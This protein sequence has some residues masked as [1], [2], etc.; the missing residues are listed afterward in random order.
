MIRK[1]LYSIRTKIFLI[2]LCFIGF[3]GILIAINNY[4]HSAKS[5]LDKKLT[6]LTAFESSINKAM[7]YQNLVFLK[8][9]YNTEY[10]TREHTFNEVSYLNY[11][12]KARKEL[13]KFKTG[14]IKKSKVL[15]M[16]YNHALEEL[17]KIDYYFKKITYLQ[18]SRGFRDVGMEGRMRKIAH[19]IESNVK[20]DKQKT[21]LLQMR[22]HEKDYFLRGDDMYAEKLRLEAHVFTSKLGSNDKQLKEA[23]NK[24]VITFDSIR[25]A[26]N[27]TGVRSGK[28]YSNV[29]YVYNSQL[30]Y[31]VKELYRDYKR[32]HEEM[33]TKINHL[34]YF[35]TVM[36]IL[37]GL[38]ISLIMAYSI[39]VR[40]RALSDFMNKYVE[41]KFKI[42]SRF[43]PVNGRDEISH[44]IRNFQ[45]LENEITVQFEKYK[46]KVVVRTEEILK[47]KYEIEKQNSIIADKNLEL[48]HQRNVLDF[49]NHHIID[50]LKAAKELQ[51]AFFPKPAKLKAILGDYFL[52]FEP[53]DIVSGD[54]YWVEKTENGIYLAVAD[55]TGH[56]A[57]GAL[58]SINGLNL[59]N[60]ALLEK[61]L[62]EPY[63]IL[64][65][66]SGKIK[67]QFNSGENYI[68]NSI[69][70]AI[71]RLQHNQLFFAGAQ[72]N[73]YI[74]RPT[75]LVE[76]KGDRRPLGWTLNEQLYRFSGQTVS[77]LDGDKLVLFTDGITDQFGGPDNK[78]FKSAHFTGLLKRALR[79]DSKDL[80]EL[81]NN[82]YLS[83][84]GQND[85]TDDVLMLI[86]PYIHKENPESENKQD[87]TS[88]FTFSNNSRTIT[89]NT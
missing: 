30:N 39:T 52:K 74:V 65:Y 10:Y 88:A 8:D 13:K 20:N 34:Q 63:E 46:A 70:V 71:V 50:S 53:L 12:S 61:K 9:F 14:T 23:I 11:F 40:L 44:L 43:D 38:I 17:G 41:S 80:F 26:D 58:M 47:Q 54:F 37:I 83:W 64:N 59:L 1:K 21:C 72:R 5:K 18:K 4:F 42:R 28:G 56:G 16:Y 84:K 51:R 31:S 69:D 19:W 85:Q 7:Y 89:I 60:H 32:Y 27:L 48:T 62:I 66:I 81:L 79:F 78:K 3:A 35:A 68:R 73:A 82:S 49:Q 22:R 36:L 67:E 15:T 6:K 25:V 45:V 24:Y 86:L 2:F 87:Q 76:L 77:L 33:L 75:G 57:H 55:C 29:L